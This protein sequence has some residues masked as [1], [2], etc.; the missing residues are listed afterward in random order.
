MW[1]GLTYIGITCFL[2]LAVCAAALFLLGVIAL[3]LR[4]AWWLIERM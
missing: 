4:A 1:Q 3:F 2:V